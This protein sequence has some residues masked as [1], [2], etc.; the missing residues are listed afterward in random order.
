MHLGAAA[1]PQL[2]RRII[3]AADIAYMYDQTTKQFLTNPVIH[4]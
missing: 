1:G 2:I 3:F 4:R